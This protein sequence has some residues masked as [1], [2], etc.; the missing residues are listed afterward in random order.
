MDVL[1][2]QM[3]NKLKED[4]YKDEDS[5][6]ENEDSGENNN[7][8]HLEEKRYHLSDNHFIEKETFSEKQLIEPIQTSGSLF[9]QCCNK[10]SKE[11]PQVPRHKVNDIVRNIISE[12]Y[13]THDNPE[14][15]FLSMKK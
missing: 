6:D 15:V 3:L 10:F 9:K 14:R 13:K 8:S 7:S 2:R 5:N 12:I 1:R 4:L 11:N